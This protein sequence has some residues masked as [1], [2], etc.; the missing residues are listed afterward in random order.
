MQ[1]FVRDP[2][3]YYIEFCSCGHLEDALNPIKFKDHEWTMVNSIFVTEVN[4]LY[5]LY[6]LVNIQAIPDSYFL[7]RRAKF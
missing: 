3:G 7:F 2:D 5:L 1:A 4:S 6:P